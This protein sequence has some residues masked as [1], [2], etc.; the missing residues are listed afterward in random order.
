MGMMLF[1]I[2]QVV[3]TAA[4]GDAETPLPDNEGMVES[5]PAP[6]AFDPSAQAG[7]G[8]PAQIVTHYAYLENNTFADDSF[9]L[10]LEPGYSWSATVVPTQTAVLTA[11]ARLPITVTVAIPPGAVEGDLDSLTVIVQPDTMPWYTG[12]ALVDTAVICEPNLVISGYTSGQA[13]LDHVYEFGGQKFA[14]LLVNITDFRPYYNTN[15]TITG[16]NPLTGEWELIAEQF[17][18]PGRV[19][20]HQTLYPLT[21]SKI[22]VQASYDF[23]TDLL[24]YEY[25]FAIC[26]EPVVG[27]A[28]AAQIG[29][30]QAGGTAVYQQTLTN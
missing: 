16:Y 8:Q 9:S 1:L 28:P 23:I 29:Y 22:R 19:V 2:A 11:G 3:P 30:V 24:G 26:R 6:V 27:L 18:G 17:Y 25:Q 5:Y 15:A 10:S 7:F 12:M 4:Q 21:Y 13:P 20:A 14:Y